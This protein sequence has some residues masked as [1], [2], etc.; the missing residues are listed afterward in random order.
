MEINKLNSTPA[1]TTPEEK[2]MQEKLKKA[3]DDF[4]SLFVSMLWKEMRNTVPEDGL[5]QKSMA[6]KVFQE[7]MDDKVSEGMAKNEGFSLSKS[8]YDQL[9]LGLLSSPK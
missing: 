7:M 5:V 8:L 4:S 3:C 2:K 6:E 1:L 9:R